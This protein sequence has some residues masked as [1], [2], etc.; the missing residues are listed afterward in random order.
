MYRLRHSFSE[1]AK[2]ADN[3]QNCQEIVF[4][5]SFQL[6]PDVSG[7]TWTHSQLNSKDLF[8]FRNTLHRAFCK[9]SKA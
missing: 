1:G 3:F 8:Q 6:T 9:N 4:I 7:M 5:C 2:D